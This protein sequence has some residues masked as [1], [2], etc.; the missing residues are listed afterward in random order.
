MM[1]G[2]GNVKI[3]GSVGRKKHESTSGDCQ[4][5]I[6]ML[7]PGSS[8]SRTSPT[9]MLVKG[10]R[11]CSGFNT[12]F[13]IKYSAAVGSRIIANKNAYM[14]TKTWEKITPSIIEGY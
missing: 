5:S 12:Q 10:V 11:V 6:T 3:L 8:A 1:T 7:Q 2:M 13:L 9:I 4:D 14:D